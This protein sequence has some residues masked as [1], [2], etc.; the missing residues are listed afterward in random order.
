M[1]KVYRLSCGKWLNKKQFFEYFEK[2]V[3]KTIRKFKLLNNENRIAVAC[4]GG[5]DSLTLLYVLNKLYNEKE[6]FALAIDEGIKD[7]RK[8][9]LRKLKSFCE[10]NKIPLAVFSFKK[11]FGFS[12]DEKTRKI[13]K[14]GLTNCYVCSVLK[15]WLLNKKAKEMNFPV[16]ATAHSLDDEAET[17]ILNLLKGNPEL[18]AKIGPKTGT[19]KV[20]GFVQRVKPFYLHSTEEIVLYAKLKKLPVSLAICPLRGK[21]LRVK[22]RNWLDSF[23][24]KMQVKNNVV[25]AYLKIMPLVKEKY[26]EVKLRN[27]KKCGFPSSQEICKACKLLEKL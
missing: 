8:K 24:K 9:L 16:I 6:I 12:L 27:C 4:S 5:K 1:K 26:K 7:Y 13:K 25:N 17:I 22:V 15:R 10:K 3:R 23:D 18:L 20:K 2:K 21:T 19:T 14:L 11:E